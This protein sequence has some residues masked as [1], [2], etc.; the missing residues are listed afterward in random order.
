MPACSTGR[1]GRRRGGH[2]ATARRQLATQLPRCLPARSSTA[3]SSASVG[4]CGGTPDGP[5]IVP[6]HLVAEQDAKVVGSRTPSST[7]IRSGVRWSTTCTWSTFSTPRGRPPPDGRV[8]PV[9]RRARDHRA[10]TS[11]C[12]SRTPPRS[13]STTRS[14]E[15]AWARGCRS[16]RVAGGRRRSGTHGPIRPRSSLVRRRSRHLMTRQNV[17]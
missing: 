4:P 9:G 8:G 11:G 16:R 5:S 13:R 3:P 6:V 10:C 1:R 12:S 15:A 14:A 7:T 2:R 17:F